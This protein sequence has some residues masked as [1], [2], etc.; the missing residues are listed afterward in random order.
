MKKYASLGR[1]LLGIWLIVTGVIGLLGIA[2]EIL[3]LALD[4]LAIVTGIVFLIGLRGG[5]WVQKLGII[6]LA[7]WLILVGLMPFIGMSLP[8]AG[9]LVMILAILAGIFLL[10]SL[11]GTTPFARIGL[12]LL[13]I[14][15]IAGAAIPLLRIDIPGEG[16]MLTILGIVAGVFIV[17]RR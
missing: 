9:E 4:I 5:N 14:W 13:A 6:F 8:F 7:V 1:L 10:I 15:L 16:L 12:I 3:T 11:K 2:F 17:I